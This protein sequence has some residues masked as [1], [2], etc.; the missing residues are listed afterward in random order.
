MWGVRILRKGVRE[1]PA[2]L[3]RTRAGRSCGSRVVDRALDE[4]VSGTRD[5]RPRLRFDT[6]SCERVSEGKLTVC[7]AQQQDP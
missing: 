2:N 1:S 4:P 6:P 5:S 7:A 3:R